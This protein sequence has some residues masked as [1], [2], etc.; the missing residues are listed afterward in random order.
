VR[1]VSTW[2]V[3]FWSQLIVV[4][5]ELL[6]SIAASP[7]GSAASQTITFFGF[8]GEPMQRAALTISTSLLCALICSCGASSNNSTSTM[9]N[10]PSMASTPAPGSST[11]SSAPG[12]SSGSSGSTGS[13]G[14]S[15]GS[16][17]SAGSGSSGGSSG[18]GSST[19]AVQS[20]V[21]VAN[22]GSEQHVGGSISGF[23]INPATG[24]LTSVPGS[25]FPAGDGPSA[26]GSDPRGHFVF[27]A[28]DQSAPGARGSNCSLF[29]STIL[30]EALD[31]GSGKLTQTDR[32]TL[33][34][35]CAR[36]VVVDPSNNHLYIAMARFDGSSGGEIQGFLIGIN[37]TLTQL[38]GSP[39]LITGTPTGLAMHPTGNFIYAASDSGIL[40]IDRN[41]TTGA[42]VER[43]AFNTPKNHLAINPAGTF[44]AASERDTNEI[45]QFF[46]DPNNGN[47]EAVDFRPPASG[48]IGV[49]TDPS[50]KFFGVTEVDTT[51]QA[52]GVSTF[53]LD[54]STHQLVRTSGSPFAS[55]QG[56]VDL[57]FDPSGMF[58]YA[59]NRQ[60]GTVS[61]FALDRDS[62]K[63]T[64]VSGSP[65]SS[66]DFPDSL[67]VVKPE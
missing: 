10:P 48:P 12:G 53:V 5:W 40:V 51:T 60:D 14:G 19:A 20:F 16:G 37:G 21:F 34:G 52:G 28:E 67:I 3:P 41:A 9:S 54:A 44:L 62:G 26:I 46:V 31:S 22:N 56:T 33:D 65:F 17:S 47:I 6:A 32:K 4:C 15:T 7:L 49:A 61:G 45:S 42:L 23:R 50:R 18:S 59:A 64:L 30:S 29:H 57:A 13:T 66:G 43:G 39:Y 25:P 35:S 27:V 38:P 58:V 2:L 11:G 63:L 8:R 24:T 36:G 55:G 1:E